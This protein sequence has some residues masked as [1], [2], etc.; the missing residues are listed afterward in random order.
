MLA[1][2]EGDMARRQPDRLGL[3]FPLGCLAAIVEG[4]DLQSA[5]LTA[6]K[7]APLF[8][9]DP[10]HLSWVF[11]ANTLGLFIGAIIG[12]RIADRIGRRIV[13]IASMLVFG[14]FSIATAVSPDAQILIAM[15][16]LTG[17]GLGGALPNLIALTA[18]STAPE[19]AAMRVTLLSAAMPAGGGIASALL[20]FAPT[21]DWRVIFWIGGAAP[22]A[23]GA[24]MWAILPE[25][26]AF[27]D[28]PREQKT[29][30]FAALVGEGRALTTALL[31]LT[32]FLTLMVLYLLLNWLPSLLIAKGFAKSEAAMVALSF[33][34]GAVIG[35]L[36]LGGLVRLPARW[37]VYLVT[38]LA[39]AASMAWLGAI[40]HNLGLGL[41][42]GFVV[43]VFVA[44]GQFLLYGLSAEPYPS[45]VRGTGVGFAVGVGRL[46][47]IAGPLFA[48]I[49]LASGKDAGT[50]LTGVVPLILLALLAVL[51]LAA[52]KP[53]A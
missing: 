29:N 34:A 8:H 21:L 30:V 9:L 25:S 19:R 46:G 13:L 48:G 37:L 42:A 12:G 18:E 50:V 41:A 28:R 32:F 14:V 11:T 45:A 40:G 5:G 15:R 3:I 6:P 1:W 27:A 43:G 10:A 23:V 22:I 17:L 39:M 52:R 31:C 49:L 35:S 33:T 47:S 44:G 24:V 2:A 26:P 20:A 53:A 38:W 7:F 16:F 51:P 4:Y 36:V